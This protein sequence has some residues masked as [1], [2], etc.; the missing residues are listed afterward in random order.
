MLLCRFIKLVWF[1]PKSQVE[2]VSY[3][4]A[5]SGDFV[6]GDRPA[7]QETLRMIAFVPAQPIELI[8]RLHAFGDRL[9]TDLS[10]ESDDQ[11]QHRTRRGQLLNETSIELDAAHGKP[12]DIREV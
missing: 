6:G 9:C 4:T 8:Q 5:C 7:E 2:A 12:R 1:I 11:T 10:R 3:C